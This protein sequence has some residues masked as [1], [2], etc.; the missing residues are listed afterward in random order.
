M[1]ACFGLVLQLQV[2]PEADLIV[3]ADPMNLRPRVDKWE[4][5]AVTVICH[6]D[7]RLGLSDVLKPPPYQTGL[8]SISI[9]QVYLGSSP[10]QPRWKQ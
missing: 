2:W 7:R 9:S 8:A 6:Y 5:E 4:I 1:Y 10:R 3:H